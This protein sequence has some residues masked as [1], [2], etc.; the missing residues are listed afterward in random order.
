MPVQ[1]TVIAQT[2]Q[3]PVGNAHIL[4]QFG[5]MISKEFL[6]VIFRQDANLSCVVLLFLEIEV[7]TF[8]HY[9]TAVPLEQYSI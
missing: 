1:W 3:L 6:Q 9:S 8:R 5:I 2:P 4:V 7:K